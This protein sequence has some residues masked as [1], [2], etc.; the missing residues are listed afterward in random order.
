[1]I[2]RI[3]TSP[4]ANLW[5]GTV[6]TGGIE[7]TLDNFTITE[8]DRYLSEHSA[9]HAVNTIRHSRE[10]SG[11]D[12]QFGITENKDVLYSHVVVD[13]EG[14]VRALSISVAS[15]WT[16]S[17]SRNGTNGR[18]NGCCTKFGSLLRQG[19]EQSSRDQQSPIS[20]TGTDDAMPS[21]S[22][23]TAEVRGDP[24]SRP[25]LFLFPRKL[26]LGINN[27]ISPP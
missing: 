14:R 16:E 2:M 18:Q 21:I 5:A 8:T 11:T 23:R 4:A 20:Q 13:I 12:N 7:V 1:M 9:E 22:R 27:P 26:S 24:L 6:L 10:P 25:K 19:C 15:I 17:S 3:T